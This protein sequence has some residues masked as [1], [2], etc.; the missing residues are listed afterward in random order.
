MRVDFLQDE[1]KLHPDPAFVHSVC[2]GML[3]G[4]NI[5]YSGP[6]RG[7]TAKNLRSALENPDV[8]T[9]YLA[10]ECSLDHMAGPFTHPPFTNLYCS[11]I[12]T[13]PKKSGGTRL[14]MHLSAPE[15]SSINDGIPS[16]DFSLHYVTV[17]D[18]IRLIFTHGTGAYLAKADL[19]SAFRLCPVAKDDWHL[20]GVFWGGLYYIDKVLPFG[21]RSSPFLFNQFADALAWIASSNYGVQDLLHY[22]E[23]SNDLDLYT[24]ASGA[25]GF[26]MVCGVQWSYGAWTADELVRS[27]EWKELFAVVLALCTW[28]REL[29]QKRILIHCDNQAVCDIWQS[30]TS[31]CQHIMSL[32]RTGLLMSAKLNTV[33]LLAHI[34]GCTNVLADAL[35]RSQV[36]RFKLLHPSADQ[37]PTRAARSELTSLMSAPGSSSIRA[38]QLAPCRRTSR[39]DLAT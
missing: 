7:Y 2:S 31:K 16:D 27:I 35:S 13:V 25:I 4:F 37:H 32:V 34:K 30:G 3:H 29:A 39:S 38:W 23:S 1:L 14:I 15:G 28:G 21:L 11:G 18:A 5:G 24:D 17:D 22:L 33:V 20:L 8:V 10:K 19:K 9:E 36:D 26:G 12:G 6:R